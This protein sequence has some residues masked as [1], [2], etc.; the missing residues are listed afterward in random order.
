MFR[1]H[2]L[3]FAPLLPMIHLEL[4]VREQII[5]GTRTQYMKISLLT[6]ISGSSWCKLLSTLL[7]LLIRCFEVM[8][9]IPTRLHI[10]RS[11]TYR[12]VHH[13]TIR[14]FNVFSLA[15]LVRLVGVIV[16]VWIVVLR[17]V[18]DWDVIVHWMDGMRFLRTIF[19]WL[20]PCKSKNCWNCG[21]I[22][23]VK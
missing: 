23:F 8:A 3:W 4:E 2:Q 11:Q 19:C 21:Q 14:H 10:T 9:L 17:L 22:F 20:I 7:I 1:L 13:F 18:L 15:L 6:S 5:F 16:P 12:I